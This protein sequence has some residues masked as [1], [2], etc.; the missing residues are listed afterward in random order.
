MIKTSPIQMRLLPTITG[1]IGSVMIL[2]CSPAVHAEKA[3][4]EKPMNIEADRMTVDDR[5]KVQTFE[6]RVKMTQ[7]TLVI[8]ANKVVVTQDADGYQKGVA[9]NG[10]GGLAR[11]RQKREGRDEYIDGEA[12]RIEYYNRTDK[13]Q[14]FQ[15]AYMKNGKDEV[16]GQY[17]EYDG[18][19]ENYLV[20]NG[21]NASV[22][23]GGDRVR[24]VIQPKGAS[25]SSPAA[26]KP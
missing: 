5:N 10:E 7:G 15:R 23:Q 2:L 4:R 19:T 21:P 1:L 11:F 14:L 6:G 3:D 13:A 12:E 22:V 20:T 25:A 9:T 24:A 16:R 26:S 17:I 18:Y 8:L